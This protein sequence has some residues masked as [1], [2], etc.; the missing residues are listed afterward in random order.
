MKISLI[1]AHPERRS[2]NSAIAATACREMRLLGHEVCFHELYE[3]RFDSLVPPAEL[4]SDAVVGEPLSSYCREIAEAD[5][6]VLMHP[7]WWGQPPAI[8]KGWVEEFCGVRK[9]VR[10]MFGVMVTSTVTQREQWLDEVK[11]IVRVSFP[12]RPMRH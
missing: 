2:F 4:S 10:R 5:G 3:E 12:A 1:L 11:E 6:I 8:L 9:V 7:N